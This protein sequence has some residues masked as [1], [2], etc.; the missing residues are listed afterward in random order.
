MWLGMIQI[1]TRS[2]FQMRKSGLR[3]AKICWD[4][5]GKQKKEL[6][7]LPW[8]CFDGKQLPPVFLHSCGVGTPFPKFQKTPFFPEKIVAIGMQDI[9]GAAVVLKAMHGM[10]LRTTPVPRSH[11]TWKEPIDG[12]WGRKMEVFWN[13]WLL[14]KMVLI[15]VE[16]SACYGPFQ[17]ATYP[18]HKLAKEKLASE[19]VP[20][21]PQHFL[22]A[23]HPSLPLT[24]NWASDWNLR[25]ENKHFCSQK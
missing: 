13:L 2:D 1:F 7:E 8:W 4:G 3:R 17:A 11:N 9:L 6:P 20:S 12:E 18:L 21:L 5:L 15:A 19:Q 22:L 10:A 25:I 14:W 16:T 23:V 24:L